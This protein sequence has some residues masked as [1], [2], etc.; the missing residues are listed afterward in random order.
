ML[1]VQH[2]CITCLTMHGKYAVHLIKSRALCTTLLYHNLQGTSISGGIQNEIMCVCIL[3]S[4]SS[5]LR[6]YLVHVVFWFTLLMWCVS[7]VKYST[8]I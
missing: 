2:F 6:G 8:R 5:N 3:L 4:Y 1:Y 7:E